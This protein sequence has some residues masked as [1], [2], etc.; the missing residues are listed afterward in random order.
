MVLYLDTS[1]LLKP[2]AAARRQRVRGC[3]APPRRRLWQS[4][5][6]YA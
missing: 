3:A 5:T 1:A 6:G 4:G 2:R